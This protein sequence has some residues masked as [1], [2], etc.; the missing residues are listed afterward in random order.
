MKR[1]SGL[2]MDIIPIE[3][4]RESNRLKKEKCKEVKEAMRGILSA[5]QLEG[6]DKAFYKAVNGYLLKEKK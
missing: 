4:I 2:F 3:D 6:F 1:G 5:E